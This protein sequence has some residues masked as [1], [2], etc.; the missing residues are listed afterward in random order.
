MSAKGDREE[1]YVLR[2]QDRAL[3]GRIRQLL[4]SGNSQQLSD[5]NLQLNFTGRR[6]ASLGIAH[7]VSLNCLGRS[8]AFFLTG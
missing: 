6:Q 7:L 3:A 8:P 1:Q 2:V 5:A 4:Q